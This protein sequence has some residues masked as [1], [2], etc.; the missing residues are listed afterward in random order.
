MSGRNSRSTEVDSA[1][2][3]PVPE[4]PTI[5][6]MRVAYMTV[7]MRDPNPVHV[8][9]SAAAEAGF[10]GT[11][12]HGTFVLSYLG[13]AL[14]RH[15]GT[16][17]LRTLDVKLTAPVFVGEQLV[18]SATT[19]GDDGSLRNVQLTAINPDGRVVAKGRAQ[20]EIRR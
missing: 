9:T 7:A 15:Y 14:T 4:L 2:D 20:V 3:L 12:A 19:D 13:A 16:G 6:P 18:I 10:P 8:D 5:D 1:A 17:A 11:I